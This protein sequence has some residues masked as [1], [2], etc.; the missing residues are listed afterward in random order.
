MTGGA[1]QAGVINFTKN[2]SEILGPYG[3]TVNVVEPGGVWTDGN[4]SGPSKAE[5]R[6]A[7]LRRAAER[8]GI[9]RDEM[10]QRMLNEIPIRRFIRAE[11]PAY[12]ILFLSSVHAGAITGEVLLTDGGKTRS[13]RY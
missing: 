7:A 6:E 1:I 8:A 3:I 5:E 13:I 2:L 9:T 4:S 10:E 11:D 12:A